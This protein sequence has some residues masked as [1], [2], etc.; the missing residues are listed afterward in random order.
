MQNEEEVHF[1]FRRLQVHEQQAERQRK[2][3]L[4]KTM[5]FAARAD[6]LQQQDQRLHCVIWK[7]TWV[8]WQTPTHGY[9]SKLGTLRIRFPLGTIMTI[10]GAHNKGHYYN[11]YHWSLSPV[12]PNQDR[13]KYADDWK[14]AFEDAVAEYNSFGLASTNPKYKIDEASCLTMYGF[15]VSL[16]QCKFHIK[17]IFVF[18]IGSGAET[19]HTPV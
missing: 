1:D 17:W 3:L 11:Y 10:I 5:V 14:L 2:N 15:K 7:Y 19:I 12:S 16:G 4:Q 18:S 9:G 13:G 6:V 8:Q